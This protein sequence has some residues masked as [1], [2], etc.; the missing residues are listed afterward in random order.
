M[1]VGNIIFLFI[2][3][4]PHDWRITH[5]S[6]LT[7]RAIY[8]YCMTNSRKWACMTRG[9]LVSVHTAFIPPRK[10]SLNS[11]SPGSKYRMTQKMSQ[12]HRHR[13]ESC[14]LSRCQLIWSHKGKRHYGILSGQKDRLRLWLSLHARQWHSYDD[15]YK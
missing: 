3:F 5:I 8:G 11:V 1:R 10:L 4:S 6:G 15:F 12:K 2:L 13:H 9:Y 14:V 7:W